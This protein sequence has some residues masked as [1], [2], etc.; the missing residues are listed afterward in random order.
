MFVLSVCPLVT[1]ANSGKTAESIEI[2]FW[3]VNLVGSRYHELDSEAVLRGRGISGE[4]APSHWS[5]PIG[6]P[7]KIFGECNWTPRIK[8]ISDYMLVVHMSDKNFPVTG[9][10]SETSAPLP[11]KWRW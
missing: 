10:C 4:H 2:P 9:P 11:P 3:V 7:N 8:K 6:P 1:T 5:A